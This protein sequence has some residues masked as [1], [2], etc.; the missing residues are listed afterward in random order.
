M[1][2]MAKCGFAE[3]SA[4]RLD[5]LVIVVPVPGSEGDLSPLYCVQTDSLSLPASLSVDIESTS[6]RVKRPGRGEDHSRP[7]SAEANN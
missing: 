3:S 7:S 5:Y 1:K 6:F 4:Y 2:D